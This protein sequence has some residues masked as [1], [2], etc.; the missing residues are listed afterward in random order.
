MQTVMN[1]YLAE[2]EHIL[3]HRLG[4]EVGAPLKTAN[5]VISGARLSEELVKVRSQMY[6]HLV[7]GIV[8]CQGCKRERK[9]RSS[10]FRSTS[11]S[12]LCKLALKTALLPRGV[13]CARRF[14]QR[15]VCGLCA[16]RY[17]T[18]TT[19]LMS[20]DFRGHIIS[21]WQHMIQSMMKSQPTFQ[22]INLS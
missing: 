14:G 19:G 8:W 2:K 15:S 16:V 22:D 12:S 17:L 9:R 18:C 5:L 6:E 3:G 11:L 13:W 7:F 20:Y 1:C 4:A 10:E 21:K